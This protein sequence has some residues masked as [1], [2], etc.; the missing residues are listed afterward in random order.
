[1]PKLTQ[2]DAAEL[3]HQGSTAL[4]RVEHNGIRIDEAL[5]EETTEKVAHRI[6]RMTAKLREDETYTLWRR[7]FGE[8]TN[9]GSREQLGA[10]LFDKLKIPYKGER[11]KTGRYKTDDEVLSGID[12]PFVKRLLKLEKLKKL[13]GTYLEGIHRE[14]VDGL[15][16][17]FYHLN[18]VSSFRGSSS[19]P[20]FQNIPIRDPEIGELIRRCFI[21][22]KGHALVEADFGALEF[23]GAACFWKDPKM[24]AYASD[25]AKDIHRDMAMKCYQLKKEEVNKNSRFYAKNQF[26]FPMLYG[27]YWAK[28]AKNLWHA[29]D[30]GKLIVG[31]DGASLH[32]H[33]QGKG[34]RRLGTCDAK[35]G[36]QAGDFDHHVKQVEGWFRSYFGEWSGAVD[37]WI[38][39]YRKRGWFDMPTG[40]RCHGLYTNNQLLNF[41]IQGSCFHILLLSLIL[42]Q[43]E[44]RRRKMKA[45]IVGTIH[46]CILADVPEAELQDFLHLITG[47][48]RDEIRK[49]WDWIICP[50]RV[51]I[52]CAFDNW[53]G[54]RPWHE[55]NGIWQAKNR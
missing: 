8:K 55:V 42:L 21:P 9:L 49:R 52:D 19:D 48:M 38:S 43:K 22:R 34:I 39:N 27:S 30:E 51:E 50:L 33:L 36:T 13:K 10:I 16:H 7:T 45:L 5:L 29:I 46:D 11:T 1:M 37:R 12:H 24:V 15:L 47:I 26:T 18:T 25:P 35:S 17:A 54:K 3:F 40:F 53:H 28:M 6:K 32:E 14:T 44:L 20:N 41:P 2:A 31:T 4:A 23:T